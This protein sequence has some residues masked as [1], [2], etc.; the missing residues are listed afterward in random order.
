[1]KKSDFVILC[2]RLMGIYF[3]VLGVSSLTNMASIFFDS[4]NSPTYLYISPI[5]FIISGVVLFGYAHKLSHFIIEF[6]EAE[7][8]SFHITASEK[9]T[10]IALLVL[11]IYLFSQ[12]FHF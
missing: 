4:S 6:S 11:G 12:A 8:K 2:L 3:G 5:I 1:M 9:T 7:E 10:R